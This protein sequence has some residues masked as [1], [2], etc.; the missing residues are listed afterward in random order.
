M[1]VRDYPGY[2][3][4]DTCGLRLN[5]SEAWKALNLHCLDG[6]SS[7]QPTETCFNCGW[8]V[9]C[10]FRGMRIGRVTCEFRGALSWRWAL[11]NWPYINIMLSWFTQSSPLVHVATPPPA[12]NE[13]LSLSGDHPWSP[14]VFS[15][16]IYTCIYGVFESVCRGPSFLAGIS[17]CTGRQNV[18]MRNKPI[19]ILH[20]SFLGVLSFLLVWNKLRLSPDKTR[21]YY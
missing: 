2:C 20:L 14:D 8:S 19:N 21:W 11:G 1:T 17:V 16:I 13:R 3:E 18:R 15:E 7:D 10:H 5:S 6:L 12:R 4:I 9:G